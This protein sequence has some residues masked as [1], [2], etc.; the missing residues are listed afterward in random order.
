MPGRVVE[1]A[2]IGPFMAGPLH[3]Y[4]Q[5]LL[6]AT[7]HPGMRGKRLT[8]IAGAPPSLDRLPDACSFAPRCEFAEAACLSAVPPL[9]GA[10]EGRLARCVRVGEG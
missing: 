4:A 8:T 3:P 5:G 2:P 6:G 7:V 9:R 10:G 1:E